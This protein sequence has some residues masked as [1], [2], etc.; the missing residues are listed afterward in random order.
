MR[1]LA[2][3]EKRKRHDDVRSHNKTKTVKFYHKNISHN[4]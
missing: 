4:M 3:L 1:N 2:N